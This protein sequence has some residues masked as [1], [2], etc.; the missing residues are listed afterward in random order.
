MAEPDV[1]PNPEREPHGGKVMHLDAKT[2]RALAHPLRVRILRVLRLDGPATATELGR[3]LGESSGATSYHL[4]VLAEHGFIE[5]DPT[6]SSGRERWWR[7]AHDSTSWRPERFRDD[8]DAQA[9]EQWLSGSQAHYGM[10][11]LDD[12]LARRPA[13]EAE[14]I[15]V[16]DQ[17]DYWLRMTTEEVRAL[18]EEVHA[19]IQRHRHAAVQARAAEAGKADGP[20]TR[21]M[22]L[23][24]FVFPRADDADFGSTS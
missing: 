1:T 23:L 13:A 4:R 11:L 7:S 2:V 9:A 16:S 3:R 21:M 6:R 18:N 5:D 19:V 24:F 12:W 17:S 10:Q 22:E 15:A 14:W 20:E 8:P